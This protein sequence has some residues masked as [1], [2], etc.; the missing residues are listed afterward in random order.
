LDELK[1][2]EEEDEKPPS[3]F[4]REKGELSANLKILILITHL[5]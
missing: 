2:N 5:Q 4:Q 1:P 3:P